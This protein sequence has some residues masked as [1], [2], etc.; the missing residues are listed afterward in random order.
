MRKGR[1]DMRDV[2]GE[3]VK[4]WRARLDEGPGARGAPEDALK[5]YLAQIDDIGSTS[6]MRGEYLLKAL[7]ERGESLG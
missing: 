6:K 5:H 1:K 2:T 7:L 3:T 4:N